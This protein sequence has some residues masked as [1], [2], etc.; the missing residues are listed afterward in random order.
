MSL[1]LCAKIFMIVAASAAIY[2]A[3]EGIAELSNKI[4]FKD[5]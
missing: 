3:I 4:L 2:Y 1:I 5:L